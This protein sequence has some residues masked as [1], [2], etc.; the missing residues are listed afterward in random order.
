MIIKV[1]TEQT[2]RAVVQDGYGSPDVLSLADVPRPA[3]GP[4]QVP[5]R[6]EAAALDARD[7]HVMRGEPCPARL[8][9]RSTFPLRRP[10]VA[11]RGTDPA[12]IV[13]AVGQDV[14]RWKP[15][16]AVLGE[17][18]ATFAGHA[19]VPADQL[20]A[21]PGGVGFDRAAAIPLAGTTAHLCLD[22]DATAGSTIPI[23]G[24]SGGV[25]TFT[26]SWP[27]SASWR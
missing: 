15:G 22:A 27:G 19:V 26:S 25:G 11:V 4:G 1:R 21:I 16:D 20:A 17:G 9:D 2:M 5:V 13:E 7:W 6:I 18:T 3:P 10:R 23:N 14:T 24:A 8:V 12:G